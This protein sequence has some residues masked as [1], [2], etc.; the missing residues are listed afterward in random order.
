[1]NNI[2]NIKSPSEGQ[3]SALKS[4]Y[5]LDNNGLINLA[6]GLWNLPVE[7]LYEESIFRNE[8]KISLL[9]ALVVD[10]GAHTARAASDKFIVRE[11]T[12]EE[13]VWWDNTTSHTILSG[14]MNFSIECKDFFKS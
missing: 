9:G 3:A 6:Q 14:S 2:L 8:A 13:N 7:A 1:M 10:T 11:P 12:T 4:D 5:G